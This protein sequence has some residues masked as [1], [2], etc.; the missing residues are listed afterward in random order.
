MPDYHIVMRVNADFSI[1]DGTILPLKD[2]KGNEIGT[3]E[4]INCDEGLFGKVRFSAESF[5]V[6]YEKK[7]F[8]L[9]VPSIGVM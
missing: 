6:E 9:N 5:F 8:G 3:V 1:E 4:V 2:A 7:L